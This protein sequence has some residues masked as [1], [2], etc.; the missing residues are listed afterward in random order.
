MAKPRRSLEQLGQIEHLLRQK[1]G[2][3][4]VVNPRQFWTEEKEEDFQKQLKE[5]VENQQKIEENEDKVEKDGVLISKRLLTYK[6]SES[7]PVCEKYLTNTQDSV[8]LLKFKCC[9]QCYINYV[10]D[11]VE[12]WK[13]GWRPTK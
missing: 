1:Y 3:D 13:N 12:R 8:Y 10:E 6:N 2:E 11:R 4:A 9:H 5:S 7:C